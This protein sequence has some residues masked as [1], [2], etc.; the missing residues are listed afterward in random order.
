[1]CVKKALKDFKTEIVKELESLYTWPEQTFLQTTCTQSVN[2]RIHDL[3][4]PGE[5]KF[6]PARRGVFVI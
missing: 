4:Q 1:M 6:V 3:A 5:I 2:K